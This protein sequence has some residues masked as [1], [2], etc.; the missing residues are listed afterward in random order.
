ML[1]NI[2]TYSVAAMVALVIVGCGSNKSSDSVNFVQK[3]SEAITIQKLRSLGSD[4]DLSNLNN[5]KIRQSASSYSSQTNNHEV[6]DECMNISESNELITFDANNCNDGNTKI[7]GSATVKMEQNGGGF[8]K[9]L[10]DLTVSDNYFSLLAKKGSQIKVNFDKQNN[11]RL[12]ASFQ[13]IIDGENFSV[14]NLSI[15]TSGDEDGGSFYIAAGEVNAGGFYFQVDTSYDASSTPIVVN[16]DGFVSGAIKLLDGA[17]HKME[18]AVVSKNELSFRVDEN[19]DGTFS[20]N[21]TFKESVEDLFNFVD[22]E[23]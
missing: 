17:G 1:K 18:I 4:T 5:T 8:A 9:V 10:R 22:D 2:K 19:G 6:M 16:N 7:D 21:E 15:V 13:L 11:F 23:I 12:T 3:N 14:N 20:E